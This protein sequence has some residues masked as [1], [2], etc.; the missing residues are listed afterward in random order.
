MNRQFHAIISDRP[1]TYSR[2]K[3][4]WVIIVLS[5]LLGAGLM[6]L[7]ISFL[8]TPHFQYL[9]IDAT[10][11]EGI[12]NTD[13]IEQE[14]IERIMSLFGWFSIGMSILVFMILGLTSSILKRNRF[15]MKVKSWYDDQMKEDDGDGQQVS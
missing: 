13:S 4:A 8:I 11:V 9:I 1:R 14:Q 15:T 5:V 2:N 12:V 3:W 10:L 7:G 6:L